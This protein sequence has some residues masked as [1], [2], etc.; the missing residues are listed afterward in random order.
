MPVPWKI[1][2]HGGHSSAYCDHAYSTLRELLAAAVEFGY[3]TFGVTEHAPRVEPARLYDEERALGWD[4]LHLDRL[5]TQYARELQRLAAEFDGTLD[6]LCGFEAEVVPI[7]DYPTVMRGYFDRHGFDYLVGS[8]HWVN[9]HIIDYKPEHFAAALQASGGLEP[10]AVDYYRSVAEMAQRL[11]PDIIGHLDLIRRN[12]PD[13]ASVSTPRIRQAAAEALE[14]I[15][16]SG[17]ILDVNTAG[18]RKGLGRP[19]PAPWLVRMAQERGIGFCFGDD[20]HR[21]GEVG[22]GIVEARG[23]LLD[24]GVRH[25]TGLSKQHGALAKVEIGLH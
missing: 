5:F 25:L 15:Q 8:V 11:R 6:V 4:V 2:L 18:F 3:T 7:E 1:S 13:E 23:Y 9:G 10:L 22:A 16:T 14:A 19:Y 21:I 17:A 24:L 20:S 12:A